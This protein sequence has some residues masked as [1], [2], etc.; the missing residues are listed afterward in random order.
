MKTTETVSA[1]YVHCACNEC[2]E[3]IVGLPGD[4][5]DD[6]L[7]CDCP[8]HSECQNIDIEFIEE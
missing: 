5:C 4:Y 8:D 1:G 3:I 7:D 2:F 6:C